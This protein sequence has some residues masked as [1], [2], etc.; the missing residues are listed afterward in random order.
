MKSVIQSNKE[1]FICKT[2]YDLEDHHVF[3]GFAN[4][5]QSENFGMK[6][7][8]CHEHHVEVHHNITLDTYIKQNCQKVF[9]REHTRNEFRQIFGKSWL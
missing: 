7:W 8:L 4:R 3:F 2:T 5:K 9:E 1:C 6:V